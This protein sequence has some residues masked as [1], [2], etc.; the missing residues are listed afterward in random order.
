MSQIRGLSA[1][2][3]PPES[4]RQQYKKY[5]KMPLSD[6]DLD[7][8]I[9]DIHK[10]DPESPPDGITVAGLMSSEDLYPA[11]GQ[12]LKE[13]SWDETHTEN[14]CLARN[15]IPILSHNA[16]SGQSPV[17]RKHGTG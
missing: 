2:D 9:V 17:L 8:N 14:G 4:V 11:F 10:L 15:N 13:N 7:P 6:I 3:R 1:H 16:V 5:V 12:F